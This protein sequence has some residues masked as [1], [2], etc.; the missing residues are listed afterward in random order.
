MLGQLAAQRSD[1]AGD[2]NRVLGGLPGDA[3]SRAI[4]LRDFARQ[5]E[6]REL[7]PVGAE[8]VGLDEVRSGRDIAVVDRADDL[9][10]GQVEFVE[11]PVEE[12][13]LLV[14][15]RPHGAVADKDALRHLLLKGRSV[16]V[17]CSPDTKVGLKNIPK[18]SGNQRA[19]QTF[20]SVS[21]RQTHPKGPDGQEAQGWGVRKRS[22]PAPS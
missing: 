15:H 20:L 19:M 16:Q 22:P 13:P 3:D 9:R 6:F 8:G 10:I 12:D 5:A 2:Q 4:D 17:L 21:A 11:A 18:N 7:Q 1:R 14:Q